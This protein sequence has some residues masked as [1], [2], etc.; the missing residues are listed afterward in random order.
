MG[1]IWR[2]YEETRARCRFLQ[3]SQQHTGVPGSGDQPPR[4]PFISPCITQIDTI[5]KCW[6]QQTTDCNSQQDSVRRKS[7]NFHVGSDLFQKQ[8]GVCRPA[9]AHRHHAVLDIDPLIWYYPRH[10]VFELPSPACVW[11]G[12]RQSP[13][14]WSRIMSHQDDMLKSVIKRNHELKGLWCLWSFKRGNGNMLC[15]MLQLERG[16]D[17]VCLK[18]TSL[19]EDVLNVFSVSDAGCTT[20]QSFYVTYVTLVCRQVRVP[21]V[22]SPVEQRLNKFMREN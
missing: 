16:R 5:W 14:G 6:L 22:R 12:G 11:V 10:L 21:H 20:S 4:A 18:N 8:L 7:E 15:F 13:T 17:A 1:H 9:S 3:A 2:P 19:S